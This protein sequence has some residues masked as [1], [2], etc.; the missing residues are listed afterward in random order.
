MQASLPAN[1][2]GRHTQRMH[3]QRMH[4]EE[5]ASQH[6][7]HSSCAPQLRLQKF[8]ARSHECLAILCTPSVAHSCAC[9]YT[10]P[11]HRQTHHPKHTMSRPEGLGLATPPALSTSTTPCAA[12]RRSCCSSSPDLRMGALSCPCPGDSGCP[13]S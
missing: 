3:S 13:P 8:A 11:Q 12:R 9:I 6:L 10:W 2:H 1:V 7:V 4:K 5:P